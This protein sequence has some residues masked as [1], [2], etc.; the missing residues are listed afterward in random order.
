[1]DV[2]ILDKINNPLMKRKE[3]FCEISHEGEKTPNRDEVKRN[4]AGQLGTNEKL[5][6][7]KSVKPAYGGGSRAVFHLYSN[8]KEMMFHEKKYLLVRNK[9]IEGKKKEAE[10][11][12]KEEKGTEGKGKEDQK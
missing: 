6:I 9:V 12:G 11:G 2:K 10:K 3:V 4:V 1:M 8:E 5:L 7:L